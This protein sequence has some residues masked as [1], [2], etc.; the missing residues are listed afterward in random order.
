MASDVQ[1]YSPFGLVTSETGGVSAFAV[2][3]LRRPTAEVTMTVTSSDPTEGLPSPATLTFT[4]DDWDASRMVVITGQN[5]YADN[6]DVGYRIDLGP[7]LSEDPSYHGVIPNPVTVTNVYDRAA[8][9]RAA[10]DEIAMLMMAES[11]AGHGGTAHAMSAHAKLEARTLALV[12]LEA[13]T[14][15]AIRSGPWSDPATWLGERVPGAADRAWILPGRSVTVDRVVAEPVQT[16][17]VG[18]ALKFA[19][20]VD[21]LLRVDTLVV[22][23]S[24]TLEIGTPDTPI[25]AGRTATLQIAGDRPI[26]RSWD[27]LGLS[28]G[29]ISLGTLTIVGADKTDMARLSGAPA[30]GSD[31]LA[32]AEAPV[33]W[34]AG[35]RLVLPGASS[36]ANEDE[37]FHVTS[38]A[39]NVVT[40]DQPVRFA[41][42]LAEAGL[43]LY[44][45]NLTRNVAIRSEWTDL[46]RRGHVI[47]MHSDRVLIEN[48]RLQDLG[49][50]D[51]SIQVN[52]PVLDSNGMLKPGT[53]TNPRGRYPLHLHQAGIHTAQPVRVSGS[54]VEGSPNWGFVNHSSHVA[55][56]DNVSYNTFGSGFM[57]E[58]GNEVGS[59]VGNMAIRSIGTPDMGPHPT[60]RESLN[61]RGHNANGFW[62]SS[63]D[64]SVEG[65]VA[66]GHV[67]IAGAGFMY[68]TGPKASE[69]M[70][71]PVGFRNNVTYASTAGLE[72][73]LSRPFEND[74]QPGDSRY[75]TIAGNQFHNVNVGIRAVYASNLRVIGNVIYADPRRPLHGITEPDQ[76]FNIE[77]RDNVVK[78]FKDGI[79]VPMRG[80]TVISGG[81]MD[82]QTD[83]RVGNFYNNYPGAPGTGLPGGTWGRLTEISGVRF[84]TN[85]PGKKYTIALVD[86]NRSVTGRDPNVVLLPDVVLWDG[87]QI[88][89]PKQRADERILGTGGSRYRDPLPVEGLTNAEAWSRFGVAFAGAVAPV[90]ATTQPWVLGLV[91]RPTNYDP[92]SMYVAWGTSTNQA[93]H[94]PVFIGPGGGAVRAAA[95]LSLPLEGWNVVEQVI[96][97][98]KRSFFIYRDTVGPEVTWSAR[99]AIT[100]TMVDTPGQTF[101][102]EFFV[103]DLGR[104]WKVATTFTDLK[105][106][107][108]ADGRR[109]R[110]PYELADLAGNTTTGIAEVDLADTTT[111]IA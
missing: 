14:A 98:R 57:T 3:L 11:M 96:G 83:I 89:F 31:R 66:A 61:D 80:R 29:L 39:G 63:P 105:R 76:Y 27:P 25:A 70:T 74:G 48:A 40:L 104:T 43:S 107:L 94:L 110:L 21:T 109:L 99:R 9:E 36:I 93:T 90:D 111:G 88:Y 108:S 8:I 53:G 78:G 56:R 75:T 1:A 42:P 91:G 60:V 26:D 50:S 55:F 32:L 54:V 37:V 86:T 85:T 59:F 23:R 102:I 67:G 58:D 22:D 5:D 19:P 64:V 84:E 13:V 44:V 33:G 6:Y 46:G 62:I 20:E 82:N 106:Y 81:V 95:P 15:F 73:W 38:V 68:F 49:R 24:G 92:A 65:N 97:G 45:A 30:V 69:R 17:R 4:P 2:R 28:R 101:A 16:L 41:R 12:G 18:G 71:N 34:R 35:D 103:T 77:F 87:K 10:R 47:S 72:I 79:I 52:D 100:R 7:I 51:K